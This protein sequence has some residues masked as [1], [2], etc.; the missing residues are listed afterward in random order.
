[1][2]YT[3]FHG[4]Q[5]CTADEAGARLVAS[6]ERFIRGEARFSTVWPMAR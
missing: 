6:N 1:V 5:P 3:A 2:P 4:K